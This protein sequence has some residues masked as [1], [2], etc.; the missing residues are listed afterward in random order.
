MVQAQTTSNFL[1]FETVLRQK[2]VPM[3]WTITDTLNLPPMYRLAA[4]EKPELWAWNFKQT[5]ERQIVISVLAGKSQV[6]TRQDISFLKMV[7]ENL[8][9]KLLEVCLFRELDDKNKELAEALTIIHDK[10]EVITS[11]VEQQKGVID[12]RTQEIANKNARL[13][14]ISVLNAHHVREPL[15][16]ILGLISLVDYY[17]NSEGI[18]EEIIPKLRISATDLDLALQDVIIKATSDLIELKA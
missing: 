17:P 2:G 10:N 9:S 1:D 18:K 4:E 14:E 15:S 11:I 3:H 7:A 16:R 12:L 5:T 13:L 8:E 6:F